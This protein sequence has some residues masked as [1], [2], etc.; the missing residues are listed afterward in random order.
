MT[1][2]R[3]LSEIKDHITATIRRNSDRGFIPYSGCNR[4]CTEFLGILQEADN[5]TDQ[6]QAFDIYIFALLR[7]V[8]LLSHA[9][10]SSGAAT[11]VCRECVEK[12]DKL[13]RES[14]EENNKHFFDML[15]K[16]AKNKAFHDWPDDGYKLLKSAV[17]FV[18]DKKQAKKIYDV[19]PLL[20]TLYDGRPYPDELLITHSIIELLDGAE[21]AEQYLMEHLD[22]PEIR[23]IVVDKAIAEKDYQQ[24][25]KLCKEAIEKKIRGHFNRPALWAYYL[26]QIY[27]ETGKQDELTETV[28]YILFQRDTA[29]FMKLK[30]I[31]Q[32]QGVWKDKEELLWQELSKKFPVNEY[33]ALL[34]RQGEMIK[35]LDVVKQWPSLILYYG[36]RMAINFPEETHKIFEEYIL[37]EAHAATD[38]RKYKQV[39]RM[40]KDF[41]Q[42][43]AKE[44]ATNLIDRLSEMYVRRP[45]MV[46][47][48]G[49]LKR[50]LGT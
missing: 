34:E 40:I 42:A 48:L 50:K 44:K 5:L 25:E 15:I 31:Y 1:D 19:F 33:A 46:E 22:V 2:N 45:A 21:V 4:I 6:R 32:Q 37:K 20:G 23:M 43:G 38:R 9:D 7:M 29:Y 24:V 14:S 36:K 39:C 28:R 16:T 18:H 47:E 11:D 49:G 3:L 27:A 17:Y 10:T 30:N 8:K 13:C 26:E 35:L 12:I 41:A